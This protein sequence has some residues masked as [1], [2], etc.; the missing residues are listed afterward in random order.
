[1]RRLAAW[2][3]LIL[4]IPL[5]VCIAICI[6]LDSKGAVLH[7]Q[8]RVGRFQH[9]FYLYKF[10]SMYE[11]ATNDTTQLT[12]LNDE[13]VTTVGHILRKYRLDEIPQL[14]NIIRGEIYW[15]GPRP[16]QAHFVTQIIEKSPSFASLYRV[17]PGVI[18]LG[19]VQVGYAE[20]VDQ[21]SGRAK[22]DKYYLQHRSWQ[23][24][25]YLFFRAL[26]MIFRGDGR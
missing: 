25:T 19:V 8:L 5:M 7:R 24:N 17:C 15:F 16:E 11:S 26:R 4:C 21:M 2:V 23:L 1:M 20:H 3:V 13:R 12:M 14:W 22:Y 10:R 6:K 18:S 9:L